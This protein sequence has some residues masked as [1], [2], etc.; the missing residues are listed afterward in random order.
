MTTMPQPAPVDL[1]PKKSAAALIFL[2]VFL[3]LLGV[4]LIVPLTAYI[5]E[6][7]SASGT[8]VAMLTMSYSAAQFVATP[9]LGALSDRYG[10]RPVLMLS[11]LG[12]AGGYLLFATAGALP[13]L[14]A[15]RVLA[16]LTG[17]NI[18][19]AQAAIADMTPPRDRA[20]A[21]GLIG[22]AF[23]LGFVL[24]PAFSSVLVRYG[25]MAPVWTAAGL[26]LVTFTLVA[27]FLPESLSR[28]ARRKSMNAGDFNPLG[29]LL[30]TMR[31]PMVTAMLGA[32]FATAFAHAE[33][34][35]SLSVLLRDKF[36]YTEM[37]AAHVF[38]WIGFVAVMVQG[39]LVRR[40][41][42]RIG[43]RR[44]VLLGLPLAM[45]GYALIP[46]APPGH[47]GP[48]IGALTLMGLGAGL[49][50]P[51]LTG[52]LSRAAPSG[53]EGSVM[54]ASQ[55]IA[56][57]GLVFG[58]MAAGP[59]YDYVGWSWPFWSASAFMAAAFVIVALLHVGKEG[60][61]PEPLIAVEAGA[62]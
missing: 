43:D 6:R 37:Q 55:S 49:A 47:W 28:E 36:R 13:L 31:I 23:G 5:V 14:Y 33:L 56:A 58:P 7:F 1:R 45:A 4:G 15:A 51:S 17:G 39:G 57:L 62:V 20:K 10:R 41:S 24:G 54:G 19:A 48:L 32:I 50:T 16:G 52:I 25:L 60:G 11:L 18:S 12:S 2:I 40:L 35:A 26:S 46:V 38:T 9:V 27:F 21:Y 3:D 22:A 53:Q 8:A 61:G 29:V 30:R 44:S 42:P 34:R 59:L